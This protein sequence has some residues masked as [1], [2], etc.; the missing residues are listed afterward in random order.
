MLETL[1][2]TTVILTRNQLSYMA[3]QFLENLNREQFYAP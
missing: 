3:L 2:T 1:H